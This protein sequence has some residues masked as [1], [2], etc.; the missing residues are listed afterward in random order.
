MEQ[1]DR[2]V[3]AAAA[4]GVQVKGVVVR[5]E[6]RHLAG[7]GRVGADGEILG[8]QHPRRR[9]VARNEHL[10]AVE[11]NGVMPAAAGQGVLSV[12]VVDD[13]VARIADERIVVEG[14]RM[15][16]MFTS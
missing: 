6:D 8:R 13:V 9:L 5:I 2:L 12:A 14:P 4:V 1:R 16:L 7:R 11:L 15:L 3:L 10:G